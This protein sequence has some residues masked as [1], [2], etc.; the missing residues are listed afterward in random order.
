MQE[1]ILFLYFCERYKGEMWFGKGW[2]RSASR[3]HLCGP[4]DM[5]PL[6]LRGP[7]SHS[8][9]FPSEWSR[10]SWSFSLCMQCT[11]RMHH[12]FTVPFHFYFWARHAHISPNCLQCIKVR[13]ASRRTYRIFLP[14]PCTGGLYA[15]VISTLVGLKPPSCML[16]VKLAFTLAFVWG[17]NVYVCKL[18]VLICMPAWIMTTRHFVEARTLVDWN[19]FLLKSR[20]FKFS[21]FRLME[22]G[23]IPLLVFLLLP[24]PKTQASES[25]ICLLR[26][27][28]SKTDSK[29]NTVH[30]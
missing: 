28:H 23:Y 12:D 8:F 18:K 25:E 24:G 17:E 4:V 19:L 21:T 6:F 10:K 15:V 22:K 27:L 29:L 11:V 3:P 7:R 5:R 16:G 13:S 2:T 14:Q 20:N 1:I 30:V 9:L 26:I